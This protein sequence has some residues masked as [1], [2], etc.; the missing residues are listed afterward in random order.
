MHKGFALVAAVL[1]CTNA[2]AHAQSRASSTTTTHTTPV[3][4]VTHTKTVVPNGNGTNTTHTVSPG[5]GTRPAPYVGTTTSDPQ[6]NREK[7]TTAPT[8][9]VTIPF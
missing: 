6:P 3:G 8:A 9:G 2:A 4:P 7:S 1:L 5:N